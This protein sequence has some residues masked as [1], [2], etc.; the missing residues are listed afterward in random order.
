MCV[1]FEFDFLEF[2]FYLSFENCYLAFQVLNL[3]FQ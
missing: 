1:G 2:E 3:I